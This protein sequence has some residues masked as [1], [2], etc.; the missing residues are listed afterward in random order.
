MII[1][2]FVVLSPFSKVPGD[3]ELPLGLEAHPKPQLSSR[4]KEA[5]KTQPS[6]MDQNKQ[7]TLEQTV[8][9]AKTSRMLLDIDINSQITS[10]SE[11]TAIDEKVTEVKS[12]HFKQET[13]SEPKIVKATREKLLARQG[14]VM[15]PLASV[16]VPTQRGPKMKLHHCT[17]SIPRILD[18][19]LGMEPVDVV[20][21]TPTSSGTTID[22]EAETQD[23]QICVL[24]DS[25]MERILF[26]SEPVSPNG[27]RYH[28]VRGH[29]TSALRYGQLLKIYLHTVFSHRS[30]T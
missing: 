22:D 7:Q 5:K 2:G 23:S 4:A 13:N 1:D 20:S 11:E 29:V 18:L 10:P 30:Q 19:S 21:V 27:H 3:K 26:A 28:L 16:G 15:L 25:T 14:R 6:R 8:K 24:D 12:A 9:A 17:N